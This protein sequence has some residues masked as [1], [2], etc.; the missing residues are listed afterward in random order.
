MG[1]VEG[2]KLLEAGMYLFFRFLFYPWLFTSVNTK[3]SGMVRFCVNVNSCS[4]FCQCTCG[5]L[6]LA[7]SASLSYPFTLFGLY[8][9]G[10]REERFVLKARVCFSCRRSSLNN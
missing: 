10:D 1:N 8:C 5:S 9:L 3:Q 4:Y 7:L 2:E 6:L